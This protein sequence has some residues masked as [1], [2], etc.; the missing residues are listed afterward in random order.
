MQDMAKIKRNPAAKEIANRI[1]SEYN[2]ES[3]EDMQEA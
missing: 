3:V 2:P 1:L